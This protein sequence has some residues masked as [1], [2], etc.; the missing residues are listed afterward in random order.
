M[1]QSTSKGLY[2]NFNNNG[3]T[4]WLVALDFTIYGCIIKIV[5]M[6]YKFV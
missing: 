2:Q 1:N 4:P 5:K 6:D 3:W